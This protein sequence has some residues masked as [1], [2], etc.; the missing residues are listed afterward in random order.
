MSDILAVL[1]DL[2]GTLL[3]SA[4]D[5][6]AALN[7]VRECEGLPA[8]DVMQMSRHVSR[9]AVGLIQ[10][11]MPSADSRQMEQWKVQ[12]LARYA[13]RSFEQS[14]LYDGVPSLI[15]ALTDA[16]IPWGIVT[17]KSEALT[18][19]ILRASKFLGDACC[20]VCG[21]TL[22]RNKPDPAPVMLACNRLGVPYH[23][24]LF[25]GDDLRDLQAGRAAGARTAVVHYGYGIFEQSDS[26]VADSSQVYHPLDFLQLL[27]LASD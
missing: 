2:D 11:G 27:G 19:P 22:P 25:A 3:D 16:A 23:E 15:N 20:V 18:M 5:L 14:R 8:L 13:G 9:G 7:W 10:A 17:N 4:P 1:F 24:T 12:F 21:D 26:L 6:V